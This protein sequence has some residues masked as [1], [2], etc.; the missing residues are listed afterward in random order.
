[1]RRSS[2]TPSGDSFSKAD[3]ARGF[4]YAIWR[5]N[6]SPSYTASPNA[7]ADLPEPEDDEE[8]FRTRGDLREAFV[9]SN[10]GD[11]V[12]VGRNVATERASLKRHGWEL[13]FATTALWS[14]VM[15]MG[16]WFVG[17]ALRPV[18]AISDTA[19]RIAHGDLSQ[20]INI[21]DT[22]TELGR[23]AVVLNSTFAR[24]EASFAEQA[25]FTGDAAHE[26]RTPVT[27]LLTHLQNVLSD[28][29]L[30]EEN[31]EALEA[32]QRSAQRMR[33]LIESLLRLARLDDGQNPPKY[34]PCDLTR[35][36]RETV[37]HLTPLAE[38]RGITIHSRLAPAHALG[39]PGG[40]S[41]VLSNL[42]TNAVHY[43]REGGEVTVTTRQR[44]GHAIC[45]IADNGPGIA[46][47]HLPK[48][49]DRFYR[50]DRART[51]AAGKSGLGLAI[52]R[53]IVLAHGGEITVEN[54]PGSGASFT[55]RLPGANQAPR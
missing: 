19:E 37:D 33:N 47:E 23:L 55:V 44:D 12:L 5:K 40:I 46:P 43:N 15:V 18:M 26:L 38:E 28:D 6:G 13:A 11:H 32:C 9:T 39:D 30:V 24:L 3:L 1:M 51:G 25:R 48:I 53:A 4:Y 7:P 35:I 20:R 41:Q 2:S 29:N 16:W 36:A 49:F 10:P 31:R 14:L 22:E 34:L 42:L 21:G 45:I 52:S 17:R 50:A 8:G 54:L 27:V